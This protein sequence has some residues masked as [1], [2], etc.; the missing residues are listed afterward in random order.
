MVDGSF[1]SLVD[2]LAR[3]VRSRDLPFGGLQLVVSGDFWQLPPVPPF[4]AVWPRR[5]AFFQPEWD[6]CEFISVELKEVGGGC[7]HP[8]RCAPTA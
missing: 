6:G 3:A 5:Y 7:D 2:K 8:S 4:P 1:F